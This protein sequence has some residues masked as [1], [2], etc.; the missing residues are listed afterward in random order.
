M[1][2]RGIQPITLALAET[3][4]QAK[5]GVGKLYSTRGLTVLLGLVTSKDLQRESGAGGLQ[6][7]VLERLSAPQEQTQCRPAQTL[8]QSRGQTP[9][10]PFCNLLFLSPPGWAQLC[11]EKA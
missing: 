7:P 8:T 10:A 1:S 9:R 3:Q 5:Q 2:V 4:K 6:R 11:S